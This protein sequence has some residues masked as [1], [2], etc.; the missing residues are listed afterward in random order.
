MEYGMAMQMDMCQEVGMAM[1]CEAEESSYN[2]M[3]SLGNAMSAAPAQPKK[4][5]G[6]TKAADKLKTFT[7]IL[8]GQKSDGNWSTQSE[9]VLAGCIDGGNRQDEQVNQALN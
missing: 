3:A 2:S 4:S 1:M 7:N 6:S 5:S 8:N 9:S